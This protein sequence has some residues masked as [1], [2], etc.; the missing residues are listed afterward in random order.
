MGLCACGDAGRESIRRGIAWLVQQQNPDG[1]WSEDL[2]TGTGFP[3][4]FYLK[5][6]MYR[7]HFPLLAL[8]TFQKMH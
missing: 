7:N 4:V 2:T 3:G 1:S 5:Y 6:D 8:S